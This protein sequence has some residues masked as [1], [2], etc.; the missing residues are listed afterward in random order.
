MRSPCEGDNLDP[1]LWI[2]L[3][4][5]LSLTHTYADTRPLDQG[6]AMPLNGEGGLGNPGSN[7]GP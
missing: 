6:D 1:P 4:E 2:V 5:A 7:G 3:N